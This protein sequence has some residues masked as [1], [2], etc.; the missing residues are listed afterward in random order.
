MLCEPTETYIILCPELL[1]I[2]PFP[3][4][5]LDVLSEHPI[6]CSSDLTV[7]LA[8]PMMPLSLPLQVAWGLKR[9]VN[10]SFFFPLQ[11]SQAKISINL[12]NL[13]RH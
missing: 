12:G 1:N 4:N 9:E 10:T 13:G 11:G 8:N 5:V 3:Q 2:E 6:K 7:L